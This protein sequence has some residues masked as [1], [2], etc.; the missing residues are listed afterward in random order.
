MK[1]ITQDNWIA[2]G[3][4]PSSHH[5]TCKNNTQRYKWYVLEVNFGK[6]YNKYLEV[7]LVT[8]WENCS[9]ENL[10]HFIL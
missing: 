7:V 2:S 10:K 6:Y 1:K 8:G 9:I 3:K 5:N 4:C